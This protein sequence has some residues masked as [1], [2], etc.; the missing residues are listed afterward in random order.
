M[1][2]SVPVITF[3]DSCYE[4]HRT[5]LQVQ[6]DFC[7]AVMI[8]FEY[9]SH[10]FAYTMKTFVTTKLRYARHT[11]LRDTKEAQAFSVNTSL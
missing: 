4:E 2:G 8:I 3:H 9:Q 1:E 5:L 6:Q 11:A 7:L 10:K